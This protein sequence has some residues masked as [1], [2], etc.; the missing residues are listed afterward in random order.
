VH[1]V[2]DAARRNDLFPGGGPVVVAVSGGPDSVCLLHALT[3]ARRLL[4]IRPICVHVD[5]RL[6]RDSAEDARYVR[7][8]AERLSLPFELKTATSRPGPGQSLEAWARGVRYAALAEA[9]ETR[10]AT[11]VAVGHTADDQAETVLLALVRGGGLEAVSAMA[12]ATTWD[13]PGGAVRIVRPLLDV[14]RAETEA[15]CRSL[16]LRPRQDPHNR[17][18]AF[19]RAAV[20][21]RAVPALEEAL[22]RPVREALARTAAHLRDDA[23]LLDAL[24]E[25]ASERVVRRTPGGLALRADRLIALPGPLAGRVVR[26]ALY[27]L[28]VVPSSETVEAVLDLASGRPGRKVSLAGGA[29]AHRD[30]EAVRLVGHPGA[31]DQPGAAREPGQ[32]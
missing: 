23:A 30:R 7:R 18:P 22:G 3:E 13:A 27:E 4:K 24:A 19:L 5:H 16:G 25:E 29:G 1:E 14:T 20:R 15:F 9:A 31:D 11:A 8:Q 6:R 10:R 2:V 32:R 26:R 12:P 17:D 21:N 28:G